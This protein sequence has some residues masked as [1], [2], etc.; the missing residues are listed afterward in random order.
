MYERI[1]GLSKDFNIT[2]ITFYAHDSELKDLDRVKQFC[3]RVITVKLSHTRSILNVVKGYFNNDLPLQVNYYQS[4][5]FKA[6]VN[7]TVNLGNID[8]IHVFTLRLAEY[9]KSFINI[10]V[11]YELIDSMQLNVENM[12]R[13]EPVPKKWVYQV[14]EK[15]LEKY[16]GELCTSNKFL[17]VVSHKD[18]ERIGCDYLE[19]VPNGV[20]LDKFQMAESYNKGEIVFTGNMGYLPNVHAVKWFVKHI[21]PVIKHA[22]PYAKL[23]IVGAN[24]NSYIK[25]LHNG[26]TIEVTGYVESIADELQRAQIAIAPMRS[27]SGMQNKILEAM[28]CGT[29]VVTTHNGLEGIFAKKGEE[30]L[31]A[32]TPE[33]FAQTIISLLSNDE[34]YEQMAALSRKYVER[35]HSWKKSNRKIIDIYLDAYSEVKE[36]E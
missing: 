14:E 9:V 25:G 30:I 6:A 29:P 31:V 5:D 20:D 15:R 27:G 17:T 4:E 12:I 2:L 19:V 32:D 7:N 24:P 28:A 8:L 36:Y 34:Q 22:I 26:N 13:E 11:V 3:E 23:R 10:P 35:E 18:K 33:F 21:F 16:E 1:K